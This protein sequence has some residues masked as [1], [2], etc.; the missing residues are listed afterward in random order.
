MGL[1]KLLKSIVSGGEV[2]DIVNEAISQVDKNTDSIGSKANLSGDHN[3]NFSCDKLVAENIE[4]QETRDGRHLGFS[5]N[6]SGD[7]CYFQYM[8]DF[9][10]IS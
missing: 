7:S 1:R 5:T 8:W 4:I 10:L 6:S 9:G 2:V 3:Q